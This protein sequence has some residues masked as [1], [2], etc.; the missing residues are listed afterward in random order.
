MRCASQNSGTVNANGANCGPVPVRLLLVFLNSIKDSQRRLVDAAMFG[1][2]GTWRDTREG[3]K[4]T[5]CGCICAEVRFNAMQ[6]LGDP[7][8]SAS[9]APS[10]AIGD[11]GGG[12]N[13]TE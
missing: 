8:R 10:S 11:G 5:R 6:C 12:E 2:L 13:R 7:S 4:C 9:P 1:S 3:E